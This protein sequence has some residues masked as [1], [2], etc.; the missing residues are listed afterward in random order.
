MKKYFFQRKN[1]LGW[2]AFG[3]AVAT[4]AGCGLLPVRPEVTMGKSEDSIYLTVPDN[5]TK[6]AWMET[7][8]WTVQCEAEQGR[9]CQGSPI[10]SIPSDKTLCRF[11]YQIQQGL[12]GNTEQVIRVENDF[13]LKVNIRAVG[14]PTWN[15]YKSKIVL[16]VQ[17]VGIARDADQDTRKVLKCNPLPVSKQ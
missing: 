10:L 4:G 3:L 1:F 17:A 13:S 15:P 6:S 2:V 12:E 11:D 9:T 8:N 5:L 14:G 16:Q 7:F